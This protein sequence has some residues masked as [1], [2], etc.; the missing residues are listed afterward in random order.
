MSACSSDGVVEAVEYRNL[1]ERWLVGVQWHPE[2]MREAGVEHQNL[3]KAHVSVA[4]RHTTLRRA[5]A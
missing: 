5:A 2:M 4:K 3:F 1:S